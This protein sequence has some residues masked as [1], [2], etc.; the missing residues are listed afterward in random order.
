VKIPASILLQFH[1]RLGTCSQ[2]LYVYEAC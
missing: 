2:T 1:I